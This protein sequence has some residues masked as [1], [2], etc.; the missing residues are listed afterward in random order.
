MGKMID[1]L[2]EELQEKH[3]LKLCPELDNRISE[4][5]EP[6]LCEHFDTWDYTYI[7]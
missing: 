7:A 2:E 3:G 5:L 4:I 1:V 6:I